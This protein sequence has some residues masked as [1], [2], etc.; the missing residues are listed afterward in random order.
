MRPYVASHRLTEVIYDKVDKKW[1]KNHKSR[2]RRGT[3]FLMIS[4]K[5]ARRFHDRL[6]LH[7]E[8]W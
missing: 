1:C 5:K 6:S 3:H 7:L 2:R 4:F 8:E